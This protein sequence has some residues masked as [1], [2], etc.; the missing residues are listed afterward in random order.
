MSAALGVELIRERAV[1]QFGA[2]KGYAERNNAAK[3][4]THS[5]FS[6]RNGHIGAFELYNRRSIQRGEREWFFL[7][8]KPYIQC[9]G[10]IQKGGLLR[11]AN[12]FKRKTMIVEI[13]KI[14]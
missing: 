9:K 13:H 2:K 11:G 3:L 8:S 1:R 7:I 4:G 5:P 10:Y 12:K 14:C 6:D